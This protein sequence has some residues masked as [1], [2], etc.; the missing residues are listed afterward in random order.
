MKK[1]N[2]G[3]TIVLL[4]FIMIN[5]NAQVK[6]TPVKKAPVSKTKKV[7]KP[8]VIK[9]I[10]GMRV[11]LTTDSGV[12]VIRLYDKTPKHRDNFIK[13]AAAHFFDSL[14]FHRVI[15]GFM[16]Q[17][18][19]PQSRNSPPGWR[20]RLPPERF[21]SS[22]NRPPGCTSTTSPSCWRHSSA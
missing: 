15:N 11:K 7:F 12:I 21:I 6:K 8:P 4:S 9:K 14:L 20:M 16:I 3:L 10:P 2:I 19:D 5:V 17:G 1:I 18:G 22:M 13:L